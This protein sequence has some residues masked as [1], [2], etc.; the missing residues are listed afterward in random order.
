MIR[1]EFT[2]AWMCWFEMRRRG[3]R[4]F[5]F[6]NR[7]LDASRLVGRVLQSYA[8]TIGTCNAALQ[9]SLGTSL[10]TAKPVCM[11]LVRLGG[12]IHSLSPSCYG[13]LGGTR[14]CKYALQRI[15]PSVSKM[16]MPITTPKCS[17]YEVV[18]WM[19]SAN[20]TLLTIY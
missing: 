20:A 5:A 16:L 7:E 17:R 4:S 14:T 13:W 12:W 9:P 11:Q 8:Q 2:T 10:R 1:L 15:G 3:F 18:A 19:S 6:E